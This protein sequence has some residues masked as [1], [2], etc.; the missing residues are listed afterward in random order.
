[1]VTVQDYSKERKYME[2][3][4]YILIYKESG[5]KKWEDFDDYD[6]LTSTLARCNWIKEYKIID[7]YE[8][9]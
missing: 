5:T 6:L 3:Q 7:T 2:H 9:R 4:R 1:M 8:M